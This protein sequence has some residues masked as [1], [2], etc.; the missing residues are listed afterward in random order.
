MYLAGSDAV[1]HRLQATGC[2]AAG[3]EVLKC[4]LGNNSNT[5]LSTIYIGVCCVCMRVRF[6]G[7]RM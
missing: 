4:K 3:V 1:D 5:L 6:L 7:C 2:G